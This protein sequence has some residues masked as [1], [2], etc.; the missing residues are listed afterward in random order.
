MA[1]GEEF[2]IRAI[3]PSD[4]RRMEAGIFNYGNDMD[5]THNPFQV[6]GLERLVEL[7][8]DNTFVSRAALE[9]IASEGVQTK[10]VGVTI[11]ADPLGMWLED[12]W[13]VS[14]KREGRPHGRRVLAPARDQHGLCLGPDQLA[15]R[16]RTSRH[17]P[18][19]PLDARSYRCRSSTRRRRSPR[20][21][22]P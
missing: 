5:V 10:L 1:A 19:G 7:D 21:A 22:D 13:P 15:P 9:R 20:R 6:T 12:F 3:A 4:Q 17:S 2:E 18:E 8:N 16:A 11:D 14:S